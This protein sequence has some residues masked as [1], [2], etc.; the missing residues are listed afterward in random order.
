MAKDQLAKLPMRVQPTKAK[1]KVYSLQN[2]IKESHTNVRPD[3]AQ[4]QETEAREVPQIKE[5]NM[6]PAK[7]RELEQ[8]QEPKKG[9]LKFVKRAQKKSILERLTKKI[10]HQFISNSLHRKE[11][12]RILSTE[13]MANEGAQ[14]YIINLNKPNNDIRLEG[15]F[16]P[17][18]A[19]A[20]KGNKRFVKKSRVNAVERDGEKALRS[21]PTETKEE[22]FEKKVLAS[23]SKSRKFGA[24]NGQ[25]VQKA[26][27]AFFIIRA[28]W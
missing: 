14:G 15:E 4:S 13:K 6:I 23:V 22:S 26:T 20:F 12:P 21:S 10:E 28:K 24:K 8:D 3:E 19:P 18:D 17:K 7:K 1:S 16:K 2:I 5:E 25:H 11:E 9:P 27:L